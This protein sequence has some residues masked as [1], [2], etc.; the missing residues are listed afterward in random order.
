MQIKTRHFSPFDSGQGPLTS[1][2]CTPEAIAAQTAA[3]IAKG[4]KIQ[5]IPAGYGL[6]YMPGPA[7]LNLKGSN[8]E[9]GNT[10][11]QRWK[12]HRAA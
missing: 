7:P 12:E 11:I 8:P 4:N 9:R 1:A 2:D 6:S 3:W 10:I 5:Q